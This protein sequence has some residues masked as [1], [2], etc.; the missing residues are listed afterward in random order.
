MTQ[1]ELLEL[2]K[3][4]SEDGE[5]PLIYPILEKKIGLKISQDPGKIRAAEV[6]KLLASI[7][8]LAIEGKDFSAEKKR[9][10][11]LQAKPVGEKEVT[12]LSVTLND[13]TA[14]VNGKLEQT[15]S[16]VNTLIA[17]LISYILQ[18][19]CESKYMDTLPQATQAI[20][21]MFYK[22]TLETGIVA[23]F[24][25]QSFTS[26]GLSLVKIEKKLEGEE[27][28]EARLLTKEATIYSMESLGIPR[29]VG[30]RLGEAFSGLESKPKA[31]N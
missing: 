24:L 15:D 7:G 28:E 29:E 10:E 4:V 21:P 1:D 11:E 25:R 13:L 27:I 19:V 23:F 17:P 26:K 8:Q 6:E 2:M 16:D 31:P 5:F 9:L 30:D 20:L 14:K 12:D 3:K 18:S 22:I